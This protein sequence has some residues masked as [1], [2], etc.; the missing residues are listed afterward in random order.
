MET[1]ARLFADKG[2]DAVSVNDITA[3]CGISKGLIYHYYKSKEEIL[4]GVMDSYLCLLQRELGYILSTA[5]NPHSQCREFVSRFMRYFVDEENRHKVVLREID[6]LPD[7][8]RAMIVAKQRELVDLVQRLLC[9]M[10]PA[11]ARDPVRAKA[12][13]MLL[14]GMINW[15]HAWFDPMGAL[16]T[17]EVAEMIFSYFEK[18]G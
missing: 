7:G 10:D 14:F 2:F 5:E 9:N 16:S 11:L 15:T 6:R 12:E 18:P 17:S 13:T 3:A 1:S 8:K 4:Y